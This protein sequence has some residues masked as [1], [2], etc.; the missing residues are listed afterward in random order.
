M[1]KTSALEYYGAQLKHPLVEVLP[2][3]PPLKELVEELHC[4]PIH[5]DENV[6]QL[7]AEKRIQLTDSLHGLHIAGTRDWTLADQVD[8]MIRTGLEARPV[9]AQHYSTSKERIGDFV[10]NL[11]GSTYSVLANIQSPCASLIARSGEGKSRAVRRVLNR[12]DQ[13]IYHDTS[14]N[15]L[16]PAKQIVYLLL[17]CPSD[18]TIPSLVL[19]FVKKLEKA[20]GE[21]I[22]ARFTQGNRSTLISNI[23]ELC[24]T[25]WIGLIVVDE[26]QHALRRGLPEVQLMN[27]FVEM[28]NKLNV[29]I[30]YVGTPLALSL[31][32]GQLR[33]AR[34]M[35]GLEWAGF[36]EDDREWRR[37]LEKL[38]PYQFTKT[39]TP[40]TDTLRSTVYEYTQ[41][42]PALTIIIY[43]LV[44]RYAIGAAEEESIVPERFTAV[45]DDYFK[46][47]KPMIEALKSKDP[48]R[49][50]Q[51]ED[52]YHADTTCEWFKEL[53]KLRDNLKIKAIKRVSNA[54]KRATSAMVAAIENDVKAFGRP[55]PSEESKS[56]NSLMRIL[57]DAR[58]NGQDPKDLFIKALSIVDGRKE[59]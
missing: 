31:I 32:G 25:Y 23:G 58:K 51:F 12:Y 2:A 13:V 20:I 11:V 14:A 59:S 50:A 35:L 24:E 22:P 54:Q 16:L 39:Y 42:I 1:N 44:Q 4:L 30:L 3:L 48:E 17:E 56:V 7:P 55:S 36:S 29:P 52:L 45:Y 26:C 8:R 19:E 41:G 27:F 6:R 18:R 49:I 9:C 10:S 57:I 28:S 33:Q 46:P 40:L 37:F 21:K 5:P 15:P 34:R 53:E 47:V 43:H 38:W